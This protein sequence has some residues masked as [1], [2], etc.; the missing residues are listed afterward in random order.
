MENTWG[1]YKIEGLIEHKN[2][3][4]NLEL[5]WMHLYSSQSVYV[6]VD[7]DGIRVNPNEAL[8]RVSHKAKLS[9]RFNLLLVKFL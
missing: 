5:I 3:Q 4:I 1:K 7:L 9:M 8:M 2:T 6:E